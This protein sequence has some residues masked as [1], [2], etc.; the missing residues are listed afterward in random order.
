MLALHAAVC[1]NVIIKVVM[2]KEKLVFLEGLKKTMNSFR[3]DSPCPG[4]D[5]NPASPEYE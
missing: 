2:R 3:Q 4:R 5:S 1:G